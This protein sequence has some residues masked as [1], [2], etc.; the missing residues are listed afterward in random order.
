M[1]TARGEGDV[2]GE[3]ARV[4]RTSFERRRVKRDP[5]ASVLSFLDSASA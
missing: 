2:A 5:V 1:E 3:E 4:G